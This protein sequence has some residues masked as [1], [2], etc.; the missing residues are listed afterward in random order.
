MDQKAS[1]YEV[2]GVGVMGWISTRKAAFKV[3]LAFGL[4]PEGVSIIA[5]LDCN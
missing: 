4:L 3:T 5:L 1:Q 2:D